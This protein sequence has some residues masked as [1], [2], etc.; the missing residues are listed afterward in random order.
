VVRRHHSDKQMSEKVRFS[1][2]LD[3]KTNAAV[4]RLARRHKPELSK[5]YIVE[6]ALVRLLD[7]MDAKQLTLPLVLDAG[8][9]ASR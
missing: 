6:F 1:V 4:E 9:D 7:A 2:S 3:P 8:T 5:S